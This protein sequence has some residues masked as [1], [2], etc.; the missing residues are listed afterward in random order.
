MT[1]AFSPSHHRG[2]QQRV[3]SARN[4]DA[5]HCETYGSKPR[6]YG[7]RSWGVA[8]RERER[9]GCRRRQRGA[10]RQTTSA[11]RSGASA[12]PLAWGGRC[13]GSEAAWRGLPAARRRVVSGEPG[14]MGGWAAACVRR[15]C[16]G[17]SEWLCG[18]RSAAR[19]KRGESARGDAPLL[20]LELAVP[21][22]VRPEHACARSRGLWEEVRGR[23][24]CAAGDR[25]D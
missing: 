2:R 12:A 8:A 10:A 3:S 11:V 18:A 15:A 23:G 7:A 14:D 6:C 1:P 19:L 21:V 20:V 13:P 17:R 9:E 22:L 24:I 4:D 25:L 5:Q 16:C